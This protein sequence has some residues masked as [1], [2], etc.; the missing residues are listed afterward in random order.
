MSGL[1]ISILLWIQ[2]NLRGFM[3]AFLDWSNIIG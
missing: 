1:E 3:D 2:E